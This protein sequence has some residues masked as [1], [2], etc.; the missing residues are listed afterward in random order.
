MCKHI[1][2]H[3][4][5]CIYHTYVKVGEQGI[6][7]LEPFPLSEIRNS[8]FFL[9]KSV[10]IWIYYIWIIYIIFP[11]HTH[12]LW[13]TSTAPASL[14]PDD[15]TFPASSEVGAGGR[16]D[17]ISATFS[18]TQNEIPPTLPR[19]QKSWPSQAFPCLHQWIQRVN[20]RAASEMIIQCV[21]C[22]KPWARPPAPQTKKSQFGKQRQ[23]VKVQELGWR[24][25]SFVQSICSSSRGPRPCA[26]H[27]PSHLS[28]TPVPGESRAF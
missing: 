21:E 25:G 26:K 15:A 16:Q 19:A 23:E 2:I 9:N 27:G 11:T 28:L 13:I 20:L 1:C 7:P 24:D 12:F 4:Y 22:K 3:E 17:L 14:G 18:F 6:L 10:F 5:T 8:H